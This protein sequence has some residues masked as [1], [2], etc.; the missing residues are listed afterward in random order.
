MI[1]TLTRTGDEGA[2]KGVLN[3]D[4]GTIHSYDMAMGALSR[5]RKP[6]RHGWQRQILFFVQQKLLHSSTS[7]ER[8]GSNIAL[9]LV[10][11]AL[12]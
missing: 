5:G 4:T 7:F 3:S 1:W 10:Y 2:E 11:L 6:S 8:Q 9:I 12:Q